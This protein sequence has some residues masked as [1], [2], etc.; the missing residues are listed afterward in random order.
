[1]IYDIRHLTK[2]TLSPIIIDF[3]KLYKGRL[4]S[5]S[6]TQ[7]LFK[8]NTRKTRE[9]YSTLDNNIPSNDWAVPGRTI[10]SVAVSERI[11]SRQTDWQ[12]TIREIYWTNFFFSSQV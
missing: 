10:L 3:G 1:M 4:E 12:I 2:L 5:N 9:V 11:L 7:I 8:P 6:F